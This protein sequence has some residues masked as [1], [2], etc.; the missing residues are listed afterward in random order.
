M[1]EGRTRFASASN[2][3]GIRNASLPKSLRG[4]DETATRKLLAEVATVVESLTAER[5]NLRRQV[6]S[7]Q[8][9]AASDELTSA[10]ADAEENPEVLGNA[11]LAAKRAGDELLA[12]AQ[13]EADEILSA[14]AAEAGRL[15]EQARADT[16]D[17]EREL[18]RRRAQ[19]ERERAD[20][21]QAVSEWSTKVESER[22]A[23][24]A[25]ARAEVDAV[26]AAEE[27]KLGELL[28]EEEE[29]RALIATK[30]MQFVSMLRS[31]LAELE[32]LV[33]LGEADGVGNGDLP[34][35]LQTRVGSPTRGQA[36]AQN[37]GDGLS[38]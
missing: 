36:D 24:T 4:F 18:D 10:S 15:A 16:A 31:A 23:I 13:Q 35:A 11:I 27:R 37:A 5:E 26:V 33:S 7:L 3:S 38:E 1:T 14:A 30:Q 12:A 22:E 20:H 8:A 21:E 28:R 9:A 32:A 29:L 2:P 34:A 19:F 17:R 25:Q 6:E